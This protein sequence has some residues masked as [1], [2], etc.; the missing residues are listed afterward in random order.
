MATGLSV[1]RL[2]NVTINLSPLAPAR[3]GFGTLLVVGDSNVINIT[4]RLRSYTSIESVAT[5]FGTSAP[6]YFGAL[7]YFGQSPKPQN[8]MI[9]RWA[10]TATSGFV[11]GG[12]LTSTQQAMGLW[13]VITAGGFKVTIDGVL[14]TLGSLDFSSQT[15]LNGVAAIITTALS[16]SGVCTWNGFSFIITSSTTGVSSLVTYA[17]SPSSGTDI[18]ALLKLTSSLAFV[19]V[20]GIAAEEPVACLTILANMSSSWYGVAFAASV[21]PSINQILANA[22][23]IQAA[24]AS[25]VYGVTE[26]DVRALDATYSNDI[27]SQL[28]ALL[29]TR[30]C[31]QYSPNVYAI[32]SLMG[33]AFSVNFNANRSTITLMYKQEPGV[34]AELLTES[35]AVALQNKRCNVFV[36]YDNNTS[37]IQYGVMSGPAY[38]DEI[39][40][41]D[42]FQ[43]A[44][45]TAVYSLLYLSPTKIPQTDA[46]SNQ[47]VNVINGVCDQA[48]NNSLAA[49]GV[50]NA[51][52]FGQLVTGQFL[53]DGYYVFAQPMALQSQSDRDARIA[54]P[55]TVALKLA[56][57]IQEA[58]VI[59]N[60]NR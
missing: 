3:R 60:V 58:D 28:M 23:F 33:R 22:A 18:S 6:E 36:V 55:I 44:L 1:S 50:W 7:N 43:N 59:V 45:Q 19:P 31:V 39:Q 8:L 25:R 47:I 54:P 10:R 13:T 30:T 41:L 52:G 56:G 4:E 53:K 20:P 12:P 17:I 46:G 9:G 24:S 26:T 21:M 40:G 34:S 37:I 14:K 11:K 35:Q 42:W 32:C 48:V 51:D 27:P 2:V 57:A 5:D 49:P 16:G 38:F 15:T 29:Y